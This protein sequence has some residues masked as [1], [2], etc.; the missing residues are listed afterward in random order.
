MLNSVNNI[1]L[2]PKA[3]LQQGAKN[4][5]TNVSMKSSVSFE[6]TPN[7]D[8]YTADNKK[9]CAGTLAGGGLLAALLTAGAIIFRKGKGA[10]GVKK[11]FVERMKD[12]WKEVIKKFKKTETEAA[13]NADKK[14]TQKVKAWFKDAENKIKNWWNNLW[15]KKPKEVKPEPK[16]DG[17]PEAVKP[18]KIT[19]SER[20]NRANKTATETTPEGK[21]TTSFDKDGIK[22]EVV[23][24]D[25]V[26]TTTRFNKQDK[27]VE[28][29]VKFKKDGV[30]TVKKYDGNG[31]LKGYT[32]TRVHQSHNNTTVRN[33]FDASGKLKERQVS[34]PDIQNG[35]VETTVKD[36]NK[37]VTRRIKQFTQN[38]VQTTEIYEGSC[39]TPARRIL[40]NPD[41]SVTEV[42][43]SD[44]GKTLK[45]IT[46]KN[47]KTTIK[48]FEPDGKTPKKITEKL[49][50]GEIHE[51]EFSNGREVYKYVNEGN[52]RSYKETF[53]Y[54]E[55][56]K[57]ASGERKYN[58]GE[59]YEITYDEK[60]KVVDKKR[61]DD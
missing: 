54:G 11:N 53:K 28:S 16:A 4:Q 3:V 59:K 25:G 10:N 41:G 22:T 34:V 44:T 39:K 1:D 40:K 32:E 58:T 14:W 42:K 12:G 29:Q 46:K 60:G 19:K 51:S 49:R 57:K 20:K 21:K 9:S 45:E 31:K 2:S 18:E 43:L 50:S 6:R 13:E 23:E 30:E 33:V 47:G 56:G 24:K 5:N 26:T 36:A 55:S 7:S 35:K 52:G 37:N 15:H 61:I 27:P 48:E 38:G 17:K 8:I